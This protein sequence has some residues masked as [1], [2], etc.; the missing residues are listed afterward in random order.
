[1]I[2]LNTAQ[3]YLKIVKEKITYSWCWELKKKLIT[4]EAYR[5]PSEIASLSVQQVFSKPIP[6]CVEYSARRKI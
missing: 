4:T 1:M 3:A 5:K 6:G 2:Q